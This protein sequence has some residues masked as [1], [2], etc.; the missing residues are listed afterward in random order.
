MKKIFFISITAFITSVSSGFAQDITQS[1]VPSVVVN[2]FQKTFPKAV[3]VEWELKGDKYKVEFETGFDVDHS[4]W[5]TKEGTLTKHKEEIAQS[6]LPKTVVSAINA[7]YKGYRIDDCSKYTQYG[8]VSYKVELE[9][10][11]QDWKIWFDPSGK[12]L[13][14]IND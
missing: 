14:K 13:N 8:K 12:E 2:S 4:A 5:Y 3:E 11:A 1:E 6:A 7:N 10:E 9:S